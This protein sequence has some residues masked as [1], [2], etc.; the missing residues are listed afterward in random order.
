MLIRMLAVYPKSTR[1]HIQL[2]DRPTIDEVKAVLEP[3]VK[4]AAWK[5]GRR[6]TPN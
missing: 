4:Y 2:L 1:E 5:V 6:E 3:L